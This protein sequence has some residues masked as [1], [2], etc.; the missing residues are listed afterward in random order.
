M[1]VASVSLNSIVLGV[2]SARCD[3]WSFPQGSQ[4]NT[5]QSTQ[6]K[7]GESTRRNL[8]QNAFSATLGIATAT[9]LNPDCAFAKTDCASDCLQV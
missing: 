9:T 4:A 8:L 5:I 1:R 7:T 6:S 2:L 3:A